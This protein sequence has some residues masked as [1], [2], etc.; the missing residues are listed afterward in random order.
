MMIVRK[1]FQINYHC[2]GT[3]TAIWKL[4]TVNSLYFRH[5]RDREMS[6]IVRVGNSEN[7]FQSNVCNLFFQEV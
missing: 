3:C 6:L 7:V 4:Y 1:M 5:A 2:F